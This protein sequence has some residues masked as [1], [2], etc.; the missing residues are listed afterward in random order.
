[1][2]ELGQ[3]AKG[4]SQRSRGLRHCGIRAKTKK[5]E[6]EIAAEFASGATRARA[7]SRCPRRKT[8]ADGK[9]SAT[10]GKFYKAN[11]P[12]G[13]NRDDVASACRDNLRSVYRPRKVLGFSTPPA[14]TQAE[15]PQLTEAEISEV[16]RRIE[17]GDIQ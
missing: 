10:M 12:K 14:K 9:G 2:R 5:R 6:S 7:E 11:G 17:E 13:T 16:N 4:A 1:M 15:S 3:R 8:D